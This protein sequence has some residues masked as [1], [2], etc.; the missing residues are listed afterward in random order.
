MWSFCSIA[1]RT[2][3]GVIASMH[4]CVSHLH[5]ESWH[6]LHAMGVNKTV[7]SPSAFQRAGSFAAL[8]IVMAGVPTR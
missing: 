1:A 8:K 3:A 5:R 2:I 6:G 7:L 4:R